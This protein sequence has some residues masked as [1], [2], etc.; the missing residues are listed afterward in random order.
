M[1]VYRQARRQA[2]PLGREEMDVRSRR[3]SSTHARVGSWSRRSEISSSRKVG[4]WVGTTMLGV[5]GVAAAVLTIAA[6]FFLDFPEARLGAAVG[7]WGLAVSFVAV[8]KGFSGASV[9]GWGWGLGCELVG[10]IVVALS[11]RPPRTTC[12]HHSPRPICSAEGTA[13]WA[14][15]ATRWP[16]ALQEPPSLPSTSHSHDSSLCGFPRSHGTE[17][18]PT[19]LSVHRRGGSPHN[20]APGCVSAFTLFGAEAL[21]AFALQRT[22]WSHIRLHRDSQAAQFGEPSQLWRL[23]PSRHWHNEV[24]G[25]RTVLGGD[26]IATA[27]SQLRDFLNTGVQGFHLLSDDSQAYSYPGSS[28]EIARSGLLGTWRCGNSPSFPS[29]DRSVL[30]AVLNPSAVNGT[31]INFSNFSWAIGP[32]GQDARN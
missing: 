24:R 28:P 30:T 14:L 18:V 7:F 15:G 23:R 4:L 6:A 20:D 11:T 32:P 9:T 1:T 5:V 29:R 10:S 31:T 17:A 26:R 2:A 25:E 13:R 3:V 27:G 21:A 8:T 19:G 16:V 22:F 12:F